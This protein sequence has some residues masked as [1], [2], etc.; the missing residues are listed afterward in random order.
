MNM[1]TDKNAIHI[2]YAVKFGNALG[3]LTDVPED[4]KIETPVA[5]NLMAGL[6]IGMSFEGFRPVIYFER[7]DF[8]LCAADAIVN[9]INHIERISHGE[10][11]C[12]VI[13]RACVT[14]A[15]P[16]YAGPTHS[17]DFTE[18]FK[19]MVSFPIYTPTTGAEVLDAYTKAAAS[20]RPSMVV[21]YKSRY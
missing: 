3:A 5:E 13:I 9:H 17:Q 18:A 16:F 19:S 4:R 14:D 11:K 6:A 20:Q 1:L 7:H 21:E 12:P 2:G 15:G 8:M 10:Y